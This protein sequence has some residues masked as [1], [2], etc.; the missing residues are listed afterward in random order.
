MTNKEKVRARIIELIPEIVELKFGCKVIYDEDDTYICLF[1][2]H[3]Y[4]L[5]ERCSAIVSKE[6]L[7]VIGRDITL[8]D[9]LRALNKSDKAH[10]VE[11]NT[12]G[13]FKDKGYYHKERAVWNLK[14]SYD[15]QS[16][17]LYDWLA[18]ILGV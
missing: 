13:L 11:V 16:D 5:K 14:A 6:Y 3:Y 7:N 1:K 8:S 18:E 9:V 15:N 2:E 4:S 12:G 10:C 17:E